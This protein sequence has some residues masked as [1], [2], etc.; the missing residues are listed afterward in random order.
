MEGAEFGTP[1]L[2]RYAGD[3]APQEI[4]GDESPAMLLVRKSEELL[5]YAGAEELGKYRIEQGFA[6]HAFVYAYVQPDR[7]QEAIHATFYKATPG[8]GSSTVNISVIRK[9]PAWA[10]R[11]FVRRRRRCKYGRRG[12][13]ENRA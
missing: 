7:G 12:F 1:E 10:C 13:A 2:A 5:L 3:C 9:G 4:M 11:H 6:A 8:A